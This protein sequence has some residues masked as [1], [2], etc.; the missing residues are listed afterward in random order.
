MDYDKPIRGCDYGAYPIRGSLA[1]TQRGQQV[2]EMVQ[3]QGFR[4]E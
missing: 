2:L 4:E 3:I 1:L